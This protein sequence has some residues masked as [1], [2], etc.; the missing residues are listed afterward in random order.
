MFRIFLIVLFLSGN[1]FTQA[2]DTLNR[3]DGKGR[4]QGYWRK[5]DSLGH[6]IYEGRF[7]DGIPEGEFRYFYPNGKLK[8]VSLVSQQGSKAQ[9]TSWYSNGKLMATGCYLQEKKDSIWKFYNETD[10]TLVSEEH[11]TAGIRNGK[12]VT[13]FQDGLAAEVITWKNG[14]RN[15]PWEQHYSDGKIKVKSAYLNNEKNG[16]FVT[17]YASGQVMMSGAYAS[18]RMDGTWTYYNNKGAVTK[19][20]QYSS[21]VLLMKKETGAPE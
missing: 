6:K 7:R 13:Y 9:T 16:S 1:L 15:G 5:S 3:L 17:Y 11:Y 10:G 8:T 2:Q 20:E 14:V 19:T 4:K 12:S 21:G 18:G